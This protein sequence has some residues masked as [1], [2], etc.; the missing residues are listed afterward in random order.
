MFPNLLGILSTGSQNSVLK[1]SRPT[2]KGLLSKF[3]KPI[4]FISKRKKKKKKQRF[5]TILELDTLW[6]MGSLFLGGG[7]MHHFDWPLTKK[8]QKNFFFFKLI[9]WKKKLF[10][11]IEVSMWR[12][13]KFPLAQLYRW[14][15][16][17]CGQ[18]IWDKMRCYWEHPWGTCC[19]LEEQHWKHIRNMVRA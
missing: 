18:T 6:T 14:E 12:C 10:K 4:K 19:E 5:E 13:N 3:R 9:L 11:V 16:E 2:L 7:P 1:H 8:P 17:N 15:G